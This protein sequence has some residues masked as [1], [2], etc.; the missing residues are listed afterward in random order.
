MLYIT[1][2]VLDMYISCTGPPILMLAPITSVRVCVVC[3][4]V[5]QPVSRVIRMRRVY[6]YIPL[7]RYRN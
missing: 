2:D 4:A 3:S 1:G 5:G 7:G 6:I